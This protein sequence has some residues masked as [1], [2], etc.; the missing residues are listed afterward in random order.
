[1]ASNWTLESCP[2][3]R[4]SLV[5]FAEDGTLY[6]ISDGPSSI[7]PEALY[8]REAGGAWTHLGPDQGTLFES[9]LSSLCFGL[10]DP[11]L[12]V[13]GGKDFG[14]EGHEA[15]IWH[16]ANA[17]TSWTKAYEGA[18]DF[19]SVTGLDL[20]ADGSDSVVVASYVDTSSDRVG[21]VLRSLDSGANWGPSNDGLPAD[22]NPSGLCRAGTLAAMFYLSD[23]SD[24]G[25]LFRSYDGGASWSS[26][27]YSGSVVSGLA[28]H[29][30]LTHPV[31]IF[32][33]IV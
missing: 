8:R 27:G 32:Q 29:P 17:G 16:S 26:T 7:A 19:E 3:T 25:G 15:T 21:G 6:A 24:N 23:R 13:M 20:V 14:V 22:V 2:P 5:R 11:D 9:E 10:T 4:Y 30:D 18:A 28:C 33:C 31:F 1:M 12:F